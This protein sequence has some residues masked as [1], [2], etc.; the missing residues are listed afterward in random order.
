LG[1]IGF[2][3]SLFIANLSFPTGAQLDLLNHAKLG[4]VAGSV[5]AGVLGYLLLH[6]TLPRGA[7]GDTVNLQE[8]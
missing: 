6:L 4:I 7:S 2:T 8:H 1:G 3:V 5:T